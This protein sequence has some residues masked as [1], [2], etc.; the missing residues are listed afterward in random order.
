MIPRQLRRNSSK[1]QV[2]LAAQNT[3]KTDVSGANIAHVELGI[4]WT[5][6]GAG[7]G[8]TLK[9]R[10]FP[11]NVDLR[12]LLRRS[13]SLLLFEDRLHLAFAHGAIKSGVIL[14]VLVGVGK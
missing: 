6:L 8:S 3:S 2:D 1:L 5:W 12:L 11:L 13:R 14:F 9:L 4:W 10:V 7:V